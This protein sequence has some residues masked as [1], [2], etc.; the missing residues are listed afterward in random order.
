MQ[1]ITVGGSERAY[2]FADWKNSL[3]G[4]NNRWKLIDCGISKIPVWDIIILNHKKHFKNVEKLASILRQSW[5]KCVLKTTEKLGDGLYTKFCKFVKSLQLQEEMLQTQLNTLVTKR[6]EVEK[7]TCDPQVW[8][9][10][11][12]PHLKGYFAFI[13]KTCKA[14]QFEKIR[15]LLKLVVEPVDLGLTQIFPSE[16]VKYA[17]QQIYCTDRE[18]PSL[19]YD[20][21]VHLGRYIKQAMTIAS[22]PGISHPYLIAMATSLV[23]KSVN[24]FRQHL[25]ITGQEYEEYLLLTIF[26]AQ[27]YHPESR[28]FLMFLPKKDFEIL[29]QHFQQWSQTFFRLNK[30]NELHKQLYIM[31]LTVQVSRTMGG[32]EDSIESH[33]KFLQDRLC[34][35]PQIQ[36]LLKPVM[37]WDHFHTQIIGMLDSVGDNPN[38]VIVK[39][40]QSEQNQVEVS[41]SPV[42]KVQHAKQPPPKPL[43]KPVRQR[44]NTPAHKIEAV[45]LH[46][47][48]IGQ[49]PLEPIVSSTSELPQQHAPTGHKHS[50]CSSVAEHQINPPVQQLKSLLDNVGLT[51]YFPQKLSCRDAIEIR[52]DTLYP[53]QNNSK[54]IYPFLMLQKIMAF[55]SKCRISFRGLQHNESSIESDSDSDSDE[56][57]GGNNRVHPMDGLLALIMCCNNFLRQDL[58][59]RMATCHIAVPLILPY[60]H[61]RNPTLLLWA[62]RSIVKEFKLPDGKTYNGRI[63]TYPTP[64]V[65]FLRVGEHSISKSEILNGVLNQTNSDNKVEACIGYNSPGGTS[66]KVI[67][68]GLVEVTWYLP[69]N[70]LFPRPIAFTNLRGDACD[71]DLQKQIEFLCSISS[72]SVVLLTTNVLQ[73]DAN[74]D[75]TK[76]LLKKLSQAPGGFIILQSD[77]KKGFKSQISECI[78]E[79][80]FKAKCTVVN[81]D[82]SV[83][84]VLEKLQTKLK[85]KLDIT[86]EHPKLKAM[87]KKCNIII[88]EDIPEC[89]KGRQLME[90]LFKMVEDYR[91]KK[92]YKKPQGFASSAE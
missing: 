70:G 24:L 54:S 80:D 27:K 49:E 51:D 11:Y 32:T 47:T 25:V 75:S 86:Y 73:E 69:G 67:V 35:M 57:E 45:N 23:E 74:R 61:S 17:L 30:K 83:T 33:V 89:V 19:L 31:Y 43:R 2:G 9:L 42:Q 68:K 63:I 4:S 48:G 12:L 28:K 88:D 39:S 34:L 79:T 41:H 50:T 77:V 10:E 29:N 91:R 53:A 76:A 38:S 90:Q 26:H 21:F 82:K 7:L 60:P 5:K 1:V 71:P 14:H 87:A 55:D 13:I 6:M 85:Q 92:T 64:F 65:S 78:G 72:V 62:L 81:C 3:Y 22:N 66:C 40:L 20:D 8:A 56:G 58:F 52:E 44:H 59:C 84:V 46:M 15:S 37:N 18:L 16:S 36:S